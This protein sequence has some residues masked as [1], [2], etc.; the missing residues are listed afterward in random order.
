MDQ[1]E[2][3]ESESIFIIRE[4]YQKYK[5][6]AML[7]SIGKDST[8]LLHLARKAFYGHCPIPL[9]HIDTTYKI[10]EMIA[11]RD[12]I[13]Q[14]WNLKLVVG[15][16]DQA[17]QNGMGP[18]KGRL[19]C[20]NALK[21]EG[22]QQVMAQYEFQGLLMGIRRDEEGSR[23]KERYFSPR[24]ADFEWNYKEQPPELWN[25]FQT[26]FPEGTHVRVHPLLHWTELNVWQYILRENIPIIDLYFAKNGRRYRS[27]GC[28][29]CTT[30]IT[31]EA[32]TIEEIIEELKNTNVTERSG[33]AQDQVDAYAM[34][35]LRVRG[36][37]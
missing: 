12:K 23:G 7:W 16:N 30:P 11:Y 5:K 20:C 35:K 4:A 1:L 8:V 9:V 13:A 25:Q 31:S 34:Q 28:A 18:D 29:P 26:E 15:S 17:L 27:L 24:N 36:Y 32:I 21:T 19:T 2:K 33:R 22:L 14:E 3:L 6:I 37:M 10:P